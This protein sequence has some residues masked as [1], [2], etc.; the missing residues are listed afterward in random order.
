MNADIIKDADKYKDWDNKY[1]MAGYASGCESGPK[2]DLKL[3]VELGRT[4]KELMFKN[5]AVKALNEKVEELEDIIDTLNQPWYV[6]LWNSIPRF[7][8]SIRRTN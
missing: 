6:R 8:L 2:Y 7:S 3:Q 5:Q 1:Y 4:Q